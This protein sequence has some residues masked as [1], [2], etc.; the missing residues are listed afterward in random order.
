MFKRLFQNAAISPLLTMGRAAQSQFAIE[1]VALLTPRSE[2]PF[3]IRPILD[4]IM[5]AQNWIL[6]RLPADQKLVILL[7][8]DHD[9]H[10]QM[11][12]QQAII[13]MLADQR[14]KDPKRSYA[15]GYE[16]AHNKFFKNRKSYTVADDQRT[17]D[18]LTRV[19][20]ADHEEAL[21]PL[22]AL[23]TTCRDTK[24]SLGLNDVA[25]KRPAEGSKRLV[26][27]DQSNP[28]TRDL[29]EKHAPQY[30]GI[31]IPRATQFWDAGVPLAE[32]MRL[33]NLMM[34]EN[35]LRHVERTNSRI[36]VQHAGIAHV[37]G[38]KKKLF[39]Y[40]ESYK[41]DDSLAALFQARGFSVLPVICTY[42]SFKHNFPPQSAAMVK[43]SI[44]MDLPLTQSPEFSYQGVRDEVN[45]LSGLDLI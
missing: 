21:I 36:Y 15:F 40:G 12:L 27:I 39:D 7:P 3:N 4:A 8:E 5:N 23:F 42:Q 1:N 6:D 14:D 33:S 29:I 10:I 38:F 24:T 28:L 37:M 30:L 32:G 19:T 35:A 17:I 31:D 26:D 41:Y 34:V 11:L 44:K 18:L 22:K 43:D 45:K 16:T 25:T 2:E 9:T 13:R 20:L